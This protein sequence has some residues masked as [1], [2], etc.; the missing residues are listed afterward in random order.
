MGIRARTEQRLLDAADELLFSRGI[1]ATPV[2][3]ITER[4]GVSAATLYRGYASKEALLAAALERRQRAWLEAWD[5]AVE[6]ADSPAG[7]LL[8]VFDA[9]DDFRGRAD[10][11][12]WC[13]FLGTAAEYAD[14]PAEVAAAVQSDTDGFR[15]RLTELARPLVGEEAARL[16]DDILLVV[17]GELAMRLREPRRSAHAA[18]RIAETLIDRR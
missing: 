4:A 10:S 18:R 6:R 17:T 11:A 3:A 15:D 9:L 13:A 1:G 8:A 5:R 16:A 2:D 14:P 7:R 12:R